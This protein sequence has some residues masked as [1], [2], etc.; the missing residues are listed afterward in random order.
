MCQRIRRRARL[1]RTWLDRPMIWMVTRG[2]M[3]TMATTP[4]ASDMMSP[5]T[6]W[7]APMAKGS[8]K[9]AV[10]G[11]LATPPESKAMPVKM[12]GTKKA[13]PRATA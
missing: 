6:A 8:R 7:Q 5:P 3:A 9:V 4:K 12:V 1:W 10:M 11:P 13:S 2:V